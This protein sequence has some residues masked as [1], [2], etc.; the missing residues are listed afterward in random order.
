MLK[1]NIN[2]VAH[3]P[4][5]DKPQNLNFG[6][7]HKFAEIWSLAW[8]PSNQ[9]IATTSEDQTTCIWDVHT[10]NKLHTL[11]GHTSAVTSIDWKQTCMSEILVTCADDR[12]VRIWSTDTWEVIYTFETIESTNEWHTATYTAL[13]AT[14]ICCVTQNGYILVWDLLSK[15][16]I[17]GEKMHT[18]SIEGLA[19]HEPS[20]LLATCAS[21]CTVNVYKLK[22][23]A[24]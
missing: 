4:I 9:M 22:S 1:L 10:G 7:I 14:H 20:G 23:E 5:K 16:K 8:S 21:D 18:G 11:I 6:S 17:F 3:A 19:W 2:F 12:T 15:R 24:K 13:S